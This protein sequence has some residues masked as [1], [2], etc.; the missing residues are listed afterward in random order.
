MRH[1]ER[2][3]Q[4]ALSHKP[5]SNYYM[6]RENNKKN[7]NKNNNG[8]DNENRM[9]LKRDS[10]FIFYYRKRLNAEHKHAA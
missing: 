1:A 2:C 4:A 5:C 6:E 3:T 8:E 10:G 9:S 7:K